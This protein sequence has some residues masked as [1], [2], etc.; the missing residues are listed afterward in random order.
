MDDERRCALPGCDAA[1]EVA[2]GRPQRRYCRPAHRAAARQARRAVT[3]AGGQPRSAAPP[4][5]VL[6]WLRQPANNSDEPAW[7]GGPV[8]RARPARRAGAP[9]PTPDRTT[10]VGPALYPSG[11][12]GHR[13]APLSRGR[14]VLVVLGL[15]GILAGGY[16]LRADPHPPLEPAPELRAVETG[17]PRPE[18]ALRSDGPAAEADGR[19]AVGTGPKPDLTAE[20]RDATVDE[21][22]RDTVAQLHAEASRVAKEALRA[23]A[24]RRTGG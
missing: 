11:G 7:A 6:P 8:L 22:D 4:V 16:A 17:T 9:A 5:E 23:E 14:R 3:R 15:A 19:D 24:E 20:Q 10:E 1:V 12:A 2:V 21:A 13:P 18:P